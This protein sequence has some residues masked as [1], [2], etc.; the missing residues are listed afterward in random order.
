M[1][2]V[3]YIDQKILNFEILNDIINSEKKLK[4]SEESIKKINSCRLYLDEKIK[5]NSDPIYGINRG[6]SS[7]CNAKINSNN[8]HE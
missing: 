3:H 1:N 8:L 7:M 5:S 6:F 2:N 4:L